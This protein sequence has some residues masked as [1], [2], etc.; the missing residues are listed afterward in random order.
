M[1]QAYRYYVIL[2]LYTLLYTIQSNELAKSNKL[3]Q[4]KG[5]LVFPSATVLDLKELFQNT[6]V[7]VGSRYGFL[8]SDGSFVVSNIPSG[9]FVLE[10][11]CPKFEFPLVRID[12]N[13]KA[14]RINARRLDLIKPN[15]ISQ[16]ATLIYPLTLMPDR[17]KD[18]FEQRQPW[19]ISSLLMNPMVLLLVVPAVLMFVLPKLMG[20]MDP[21]AQKDMEESMQKLQSG[22]DKMPEIADLF[23][24]WFGG[25]QSGKEVRKALK[26]KRN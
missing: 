7:T 3:Y 21:G 24:N 16:D 11:N 20:S 22:K 2:F 18:Y 23:T 26:K 6:R 14:D 9:S 17:P 10:V 1:M 4:I 8:R 12:I 5:E 15:Q 13:P 19:N 25:G